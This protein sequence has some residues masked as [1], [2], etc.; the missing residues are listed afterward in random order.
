MKPQV[1]KGAVVQ[2]SHCILLLMKLWWTYSACGYIGSILTMASLTN[3][4]KM[5]SIILVETC[6]KAGVILQSL[7]QF[8]EF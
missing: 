3:L 5:F 8:M 2:S 7:L 6:K 1:V 4:K